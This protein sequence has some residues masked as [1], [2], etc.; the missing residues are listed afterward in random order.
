[1]PTSQPFLFI[2]LT[3]ITSSLTHINAEPVRAKRLLFSRDNSS[4]GGWGLRMV[5]CPAETQTCSKFSIGCCPKDMF[6][7]S[8]SLM[9]GL[10]CCPTSISPPL[11]RSAPFS[12]TGKWEWE[13]VGKFVDD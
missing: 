3:L 12:M 8:D 13:P 1:M 6:C 4:F 10:S 7:I 5:N 11:F 9:G 2:L